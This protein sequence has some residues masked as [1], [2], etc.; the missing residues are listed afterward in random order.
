MPFPL[1]DLFHLPLFLYTSKA[2]RSYLEGAL[3]LAETVLT[4]DQRAFLKAPRSQ[5]QEENE[6]MLQHINRIEKDA[7]RKMLGLEGK[8]KSKA[9]PFVTG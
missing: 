8:K 2:N 4:D 9:Q 3:E 5:G 6:T 7:M 1:F